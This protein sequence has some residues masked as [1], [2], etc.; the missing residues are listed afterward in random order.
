MQR[1]PKHNRCH[2]I[3]QC[4]VIKITIKDNHDYHQDYHDYHDHQDNNKMAER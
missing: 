2:Q 4:K 3:S 1:V